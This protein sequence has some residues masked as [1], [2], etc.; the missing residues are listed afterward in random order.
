MVS[1]LKG[2][3]IIITTTTTTTTIMDFE[4]KKLKKARAIYFSNL[5][6]RTLLKT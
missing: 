5:E 6:I 2:T 3:I 1:T 4:P